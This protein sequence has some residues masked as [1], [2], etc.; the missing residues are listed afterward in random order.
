M[1]PG[2]ESRR[3]PAEWEPQAAI[4]L[5]WPHD[6]E[7]WGGDFE[8]VQRCFRAIALAIADHQPLLV[9]C[10][11]PAHREEVRRLLGDP[12]GVRYHCLPSD[13]CWVRDHGPVGVLV[14]GRPRLLDFRFNGWGGKFPAADDDALSGRLAA[15]GAFG[16]TPVERVE[17]V[18]EGGSIDG[19][20]AGELLT[21]ASC[22]LHPGRNPG[23]DRREMEASLAR[24]LGC[25]HQHW[26][27]QGRLEG[28]DTDG[29]I[30]T[31]ARFVAPDA[32]VHVS[33]DDPADHNHD[34]LQRMAQE[35]AMLRRPDGT[36]YRLR[37]LPS[38]PP[39]RD[40]QGRQYPAS[41][42]NFLVTNHKVLLPGYHPSSDALAREVL[43]ESFPDR[44]VEVIDC[45]PLIRQSGSLHCVT[46]QLPKGV[47][48]G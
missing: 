11:D 37:P 12:P 15:A 18:L 13:D 32:I 35:L 5:T 26:L 39:I 25:P 21:T 34:T 46:M 22:L 14:E 9:T 2:T 44:R 3:L 10:R 6:P 19:N 40:P 27:E 41:Y 31:L 8:A 17:L 38:P 7:I 42:A 24:L 29:H 23:L 48:C 28:D 4:L 20:G 1:L 33:C 16:D 47:E 43:A 30:D 45:L 36:P